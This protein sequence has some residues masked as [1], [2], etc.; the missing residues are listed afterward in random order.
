MTTQ[1]GLTTI[2]DYKDFLRRRKWQIIIPW[3]LVTLIAGGIAYVLPPVYR[4]TSTILIESQQVPQDL[5]RT[6]VTGY[7]EERIKAITAQ[8]LSRQV[9]LKIVKDFDLYPK[10]RSNA[11]VE[12]ILDQMKKDISIEM[13]SAEVPDRRGGRP[14]TVNVAFTVSYEGHDPQK[15][16]AVTNRLTSLFLEHNLQMREGLAKTTTKFLKQQLDQYREITRKLEEKIAKFKEAHIKE[17]PELMN[18]NF[19]TERQLRHQIDSLDDQIRTLKDRIV[20]LEGQLATV[21]PDINTVDAN[22][23]IIADPAQRLKFLKNQLVTM[24]A[25]LSPK[26]PD[27]IK[28]KREIAELEKQTGDTAQKTELEKLLKAKREKLRQLSSTLKPRHPDIIK[29]KKEIKTL[30]EQLAK[31]RQKTS[32]T[33]DSAPTNPAYIN[34][35]TQIKAAQIDLEGLKRKKRQLEAKWQ[36]YVKRL[37]MMPSVEKQYRDLTRDYDAAQQQYRETMAK[38]MEAQQGQSLEQHQAGEKFTVID[39]PEL[40]ERPIKPNRPAI[41]LIGFILGMG[42]GVGIAATAEMADSTIRTAKD[43]KRITGKPVLA[44]I[45][46]VAKIKKI[47]GKKG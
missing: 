30:E 42:L 19:E 44:S 16:M 29:L 40:P 38:L 17:L 26:H 10:K 43:V 12:D 7:A 37:E 3:I 15:V 28:L 33:L 24:E 1:S 4:S 6:T 9:L 27:V 22:G 20:Y 25:N 21:S 31:A 34:L 41:V 35:E 13:I 18:I 23:K 14:V 47:R 11:P 8:I 46:D 32:P 36:D 2:E 39:P 5:I 45:A